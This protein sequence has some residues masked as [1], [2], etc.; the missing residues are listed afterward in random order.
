MPFDDF[1]DFVGGVNPGVYWW[2]SYNFLIARQQYI[3]LVQL[4]FILTFSICGTMVPGAFQ[5]RNTAASYV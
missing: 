5:E 1:V 3:Y 2:T 4:I